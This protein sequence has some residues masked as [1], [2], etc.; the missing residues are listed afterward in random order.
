M[1]TS[2]AMKT[3]Y[4]SPVKT[5]L[6]FVL[7]GTVMFALFTQAAENAVTSRELASAAEQYYGV[8]TVE[9]E[10]PGEL[11]PSF[12]WA[13]SL[14][15]GNALVFQEGTGSYT[16]L[17]RQLTNE[18]IEEIS[19]LP[20]VTS[21]DTRYMTAGYSDMYYRIDEGSSFYR[22]TDRCVIEGTLVNTVFLDAEYTLM[23]SDCKL[24]AGYTKDL[25]QGPAVVKALSNTPQRVGGLA[26]G[27]RTAY[28]FT[29]NYK[30]NAEFARENLIPGERYVFVLSIDPASAQGHYYLYD[31]LSDN[32][33]SAIW[34]VARSATG[35]TNQKAP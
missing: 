5:I 8:G 20:Y 19:A 31:Y 16:P 29:P 30:Y 24:H 22:Y 1:K 28:I 9:I 14:D 4:R 7:L 23:L 21:T 12:P 33:C 34:P 32:A 15:N 26:S 18:Q 35:R 25:V 11:D 10:Q 27:Q 6:T 3:L 2:L 17:Y 13:L